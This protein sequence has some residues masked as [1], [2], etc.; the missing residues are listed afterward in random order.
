M[1][2]GHKEITVCFCSFLL[3]TFFLFSDWLFGSVTN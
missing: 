1:S 2:S 3:E